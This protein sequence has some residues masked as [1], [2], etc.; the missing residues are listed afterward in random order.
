M[1]G[2]VVMR[3]SS[4]TRGLVRAMY[5]LVLPTK[6]AFERADFGWFAFDILLILNQ[7]WRCAITSLNEL[8]GIDFSSG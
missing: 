8:A 6:P 1:V 5:A 3:S 2:T 4:M 7:P